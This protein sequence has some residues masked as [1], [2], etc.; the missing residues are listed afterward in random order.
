M[1]KK[2]LQSGLTLI[3]LLIFMSLYSV[4]LVIIMSVFTA[5]IDIKLSSEATSNVQED[6]NFLMSRLSYDVLRANSITLPDLGDTNSSLELNIDGESYTYELN[7][8]NLEL[9]NDAGT[10]QLNMYNTSITDLS[11]TRLG[12]TS[13]KN[14]LQISFT[15]NSRIANTSGVTETKDFQTT[16]GTR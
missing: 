4:L 7:N 3:E 13:G 8:T 6:G 9:T 15:I 16:L 5:T 10:D 1:T 2:S 12:E 11:F 14:T